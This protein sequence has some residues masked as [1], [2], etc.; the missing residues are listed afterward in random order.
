M[1]TPGIDLDITDGIVSV[2]ADS[3]SPRIT[4]STP[5]LSEQLAAAEISQSEL[6][7][8]LGVS[9]GLVSHWC[10]GRKRI[11]AER[12]RDIELATGGR[13]SRQALRP[14]VFEGSGP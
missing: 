3:T 12:A 14:D 1:I 6:A 10:T 2:M 4:G 8:K 5:T 13:I 11:T 7:E 9:H